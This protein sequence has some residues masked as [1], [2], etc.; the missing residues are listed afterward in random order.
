MSRR[1]HRRAFDDYIAAYVEEV[2]ESRYSE[3]RSGQVAPHASLARGAGGV[4]YMLWRLGRMDEARTWVTALLADR[5]RNAYHYGRF[6]PPTSSYMYGRAGLQW[7]RALIGGPGR[8]RAIGDYLR[9]A[10]QA[11]RKSDFMQSAA[12]HL[13]AARLLLAQGEHDELRVVA[14]LLAATLME[15]VRVRSKRPWRPADA[16][17]FAFGWPGVLHAVLAWLELAKQRPPRWLV[18]SLLRLRRVWATSTPDPGFLAS[19]CNGAAGT[20]MLWARAFA[21]TQDQELLDAA[22]DGARRALAVD[23]RRN[24]LCCGLGGVAYALLAVARVDVRGDWYDLARRRGLAAITPQGMTWPNGLYLGHPG[25][26]CLADD[27]A[28]DR[29][30]GFPAIDG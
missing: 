27:L 29:L 20:T 7:L 6:A 21:C 8:A 5:A 30:S 18:G 3:L 17:G 14:E 24:Y 26:V 23:E 16:H 28:R 25:L 10:R 1:S 2:G 4:A 22:R 9:L 19:W 15:R 13:T 12:G 11:K